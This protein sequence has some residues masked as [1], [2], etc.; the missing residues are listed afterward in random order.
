MSDDAVPRV[1]W[2]VALLLV[3]L[4]V[5][6][7]PGL[8]AGDR[9][10][11]VRRVTIYATLQ[12]P[13]ES[14]HWVDEGDALWA[15]E[16]DN[17]WPEGTSACDLVRTDLGWAFVAGALAGAPALFLWWRR[18]S[19]ALARATGIA[20]AIA[21]AVSATALATS[22]LHPWKL[23]PGI[24]WTVPVGAAVMAAAFLVAP[25]PQVRDE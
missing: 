11:R 17:A 4:V 10:V 19:L 8:A 21:A 14:E 5:A 6:F 15:W 16:F 18:A 23:P 2:A 20:C 7:V 22:L 25:A 9:F 3:G 24:W 1:R 12:G 13:A